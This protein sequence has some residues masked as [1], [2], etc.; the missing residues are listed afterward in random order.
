MALEGGQT[1]FDVPA[2]ARLAVGIGRQQGQGRVGRRLARAVE[3]EQ[4][5]H[6]GVGVRIHRNFDLAAFGQGPVTAND[7]AHQLADHDQQLVAFVQGVA[8]AFFIRRSTRASCRRTV[9]PIQAR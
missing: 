1:L 6:D 7:A 8:A 5:G 9:S 3:V 4:Q 2:G